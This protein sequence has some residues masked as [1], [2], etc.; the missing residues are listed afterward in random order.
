MRDLTTTKT[1]QF[2]VSTSVRYYICF[3]VEEMYTSSYTVPGHIVLYN[4]FQNTL[5]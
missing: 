1:L 5:V 3:S 4:H 2:F